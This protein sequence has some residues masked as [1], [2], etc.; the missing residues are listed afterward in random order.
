MMI[1]ART[2][3]K[4]SQFGNVETVTIQQFET[5][6]FWI[7]STYDYEPARSSISV[8]RI[9][10]RTDS[11][12]LKPKKLELKEL[13]TELEFLRIDAKNLSNVPNWGEQEMAENMD[14]KRFIKRVEDNIDDYWRPE[15]ERQDR[16]NECFWMME[17]DVDVSD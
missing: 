1:T 3:I 4:K 8:S 16:E 15:Y 12:K 14:N 6:S 17:E 11:S 10:C 9:S 5:P 7:E 2:Q 13:T